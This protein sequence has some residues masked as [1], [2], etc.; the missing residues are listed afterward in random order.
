MTSMQDTPYPPRPL[1]DV[2]VAWIAGLFEGEGSSVLGTCKYVDPATGKLRVAGARVSV[3]MTDRDVIERLERF[4]PC[5]NGIYVRRK[6]EKPHYK[7]QYVWRLGQ[8]DQVRTFLRTVL[9][10]LGERR[11][12]Q[13]LTVL[14]Y[15]ED[16]AKGNGSQ[17]RNKKHCPQGHLYDEAN[18]ILK[19]QRNGHGYSRHCRAC[20]N[21]AALDRYYRRQREAREAKDVSR[22]SNQPLGGLCNSQ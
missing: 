17:H 10:Y 21:Q 14:A 22:A 19:P 5:T 7:T 16:P 20:R 9:P 8:R 15:V 1:S 13:A 2:E 3:S 18:T 6:V 4:F 11:T 12:A